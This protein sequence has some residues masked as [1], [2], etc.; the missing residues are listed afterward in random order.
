MQLRASTIVLEEVG[1]S[2]WMIVACI[3]H[4]FFVVFGIID[5]D[6]NIDD[7]NAIEDDHRPLL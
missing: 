6:D 7:D 4:D 2:G 3:L 5:D 1:V